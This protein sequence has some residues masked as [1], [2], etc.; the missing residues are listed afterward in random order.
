MNRRPDGAVS[1]TILHIEGLFRA[2]DVT[3]LENGGILAVRAFYEGAFRQVLLY[4]IF[5]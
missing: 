3:V 2:G 5:F 1:E 4:L